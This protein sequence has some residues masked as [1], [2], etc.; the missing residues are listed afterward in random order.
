MKN[1]TTVAIL[2]EIQTKPLPNKSQKH[3]SFSID[4]QTYWDEVRGRVKLSLCLKTYHDKK[5]Y[6]EE[7]I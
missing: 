1:L 2:A 5:A 4:M 6:G 3:Y 7:E